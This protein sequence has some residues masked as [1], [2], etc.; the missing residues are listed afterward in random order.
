MPVTKVKTSPNRAKINMHAK[1][2]KTKAQLG[3]FDTELFIVV[4]F[5]QK[6]MHF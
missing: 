5:L 6:Y 2:V 1:K 4:L 3:N